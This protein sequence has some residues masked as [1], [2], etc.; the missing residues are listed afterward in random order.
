MTMYCSEFTGWG[1]Q[2]RYRAMIRQFLVALVAG[3]MLAP[4]TADARDGYGRGGSHAPYAQQGYAREGRGGGYAPYAQGQGQ[5]QGQAQQ[6]PKGGSQVQRG[7]SRRSSR[8]A[9]SGRTAR[10]PTP[11]GPAS[12]LANAGGA[13]SIPDNW[14][15]APP[16]NFNV[17]GN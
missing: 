15:L 14:N 6:G 8:P 13:V 12:R 3:V 1:L 11:R 16:T 17:L 4:L 10:N 5:G 9:S 2:M 7:G